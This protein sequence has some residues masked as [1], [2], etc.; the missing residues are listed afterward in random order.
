[1]VSKHKI[2]E[3]TY[4]KW[5]YEM[6]TKGT[7][8]GRTIFDYTKYSK[9]NIKDVIIYCKPKQTGKRYPKVKNINTDYAEYLGRVLKQ[10][11]TKRAVVKKAKAT[12]K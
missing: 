6:N 8:L 10:Y 4:Y 1:M 3:K 2:S 11:L 7:L 9:K 5:I 12:A